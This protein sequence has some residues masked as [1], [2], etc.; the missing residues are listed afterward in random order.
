MGS[1]AG[2]DSSERWEDTGTNLGT[3]Q[4]HVDPVALLAKTRNHRLLCL[5]Q[6]TTLLK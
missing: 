3:R 6:L 1:G 2:T 4:S 5:Q